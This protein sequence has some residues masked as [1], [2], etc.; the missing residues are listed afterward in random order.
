MTDKNK[1]EKNNVFFCEKC[2]YT[3][4]ILQR[5]QRHTDTQK[6]KILTAPVV[7]SFNC[8]CGKKYKH[9]Q[10]LFNHKQQNQCNNECNIENNAVN[11]MQKEGNIVKNEKPELDTNE[12]II[13]LLQQN[14][15]LQ[16][17]LIEIS[18]DKNNIINNNLSSHKTFN[19]N[20]FL[21]EQC[22]DA[23][24]I[25][26]FVDSIKIQLPDLETTGRMGYVEGVSKIINKNLK[27]LDKC[28]RPIHCSDLKREVLYIKDNNEWAKDDVNKTI[29][30]KA[31]KQIA[32][33][34]IQEIMTWK[35]KYID[36]DDSDSTKNDLYLK[37]IFNSMSG[38][39][40]EEQ[41]NNY[42]KITS[43]VI[44]TVVIDK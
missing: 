6:H 24:N 5:W 4:S 12:L 25:S 44:K 10:S 41:T 18:K 9:R 42:E 28:K 1:Y 23:L 16:K 11:A 36:C 3:C 14:Q 21:N 32:N 33:K 39:T 2:D 22:K 8:S 37:I 35:N 26:D 17:S 20:F 27:E 15:E 43:N 7:K 29:L 19:L 40:I 34:N 30:K 13:K 38:S 31:I